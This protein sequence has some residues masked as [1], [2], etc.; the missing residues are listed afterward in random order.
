MQRSRL[1][2]WLDQAGLL[3]AAA[4]LVVLLYTLPIAYGVLVFWPPRLHGLPFSL[5]WVASWTVLQA[6][7][8][9]SL[10]VA[11][12]WPLGLLAG[13]YGHRAARAAVAA[14][15]APFMSPVVVAALGLRALYQDTLLGF[16]THGWT[17]VLALHSYFN[18]GLAAGFTAAA[19]ASTERSVL[20]HARLLGL[21]GP[22]LW[23]RVLLPLTSRAALAA[24]LLAF[25]YSA[26]SAGPLLVRGAAYK[27]YTVE[28]WLYTLY[29][30]FPSML[31]SVP[32]LA[33]GELAAAALFAAL[34]S[35]ASLGAEAPLAARGAGILPLRGPSSLA[36]SAYAATVTVYLYAPLAA[37]ALNAR[38]AS[39]ELLAS[40]VG[41]PGLA[42]AVANSLLYASTVA[43]LAL[44]LGVAAAVRRGLGVA[45]LSTVAVAPVAY[46][47]S[48][49]LVY[50]HALSPLL[51]AAATSRLLIV[52]AHLAAALPLST[53]LLEAAKNRMP[54]EVEDTMLLLGL[55]GLRLLLHWLRAAGPMAAVAAGFAAAASLGEFGATVVVSVPK[56]WSLTVL[57]Y[58]LMGSGRLFH[59]A[60]LAAL[61]LEAL[62][63]ASIALPLYLMGWSG[64]GAG[65]NL[66]GSVRRHNANIYNQ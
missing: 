31:G 43:A 57:V 11:A 34:V 9:A 7:A 62:S 35:R 56:T 6:A 25:L 61:V 4:W 50:Y 46:G 26:T 36:A 41:G 2:G 51:G 21:R 33:A 39:L 20:E 29:T 28:A 14:S 55:R 59:E 24:W 3:G 49:T 48:A 58:R 23:L 32:L 18:I 10:A 13:F 30:G 38:G 60:C 65:R 22:G 53:K 1:G 63:L 64:R 47:V 12:G 16:L 52:L 40:R 66:W 27:Y 37:L 8:S 45:A 42:G 44:P 54:G 17:G 19:A 5:S 15:L